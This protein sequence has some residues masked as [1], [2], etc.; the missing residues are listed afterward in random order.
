MPMSD[1][2]FRKKTG[3]IF[4]YAEQYLEAKI[5]LTKLH[6]TEKI[7][8]ISSVFISLLVIGLILVLT[9]LFFL[10]TLTLLLGEYLGSYSLAFG[11]V[12]IGLFVLFLLITVLRKK[13]LETPLV[14]GIIRKLYEE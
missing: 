2:N 12:T 11:Y 3:E 6:A 1:S 5:E 10:V 13:I 4:T 9:F 8:K 7:A 14:N